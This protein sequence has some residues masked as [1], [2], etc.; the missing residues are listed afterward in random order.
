MSF[1]TE[2]SFVYKVSFL[3]VR[4]GF[5]LTKKRQNDTFDTVFP[6]ATPSVVF[7]THTY[8]L[9][10]ANLTRPHSRRGTEN[11]GSNR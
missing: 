1:L 7:N 2:L 11:E 10:P 8:L 9:G 3:L 4:R 5:S 6:R